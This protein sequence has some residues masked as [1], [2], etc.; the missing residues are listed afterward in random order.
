MFL[1]QETFYPDPCA[2]PSPDP[3]RF[4]AAGRI[5]IAAGHAAAGSAKA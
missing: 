2:T 1:F 4:G 5:R 3:E